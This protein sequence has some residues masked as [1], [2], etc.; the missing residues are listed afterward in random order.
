[1]R[2][3]SSQV[4]IICVHTISALFR[5]YFGELYGSVQQ[6]YENTFHWRLLCT[7][8][9]TALSGLGVVH[10]VKIAVRYL[11]GIIYVNTA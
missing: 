1:M 11:P 10:V 2:Y 3:D 7:V 8:Y 6:M 4:G 9:Q 5:S